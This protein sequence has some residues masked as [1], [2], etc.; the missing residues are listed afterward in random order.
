M[1][2]HI[3]KHLFSLVPTLLGVTILVFLLIH[4]IP[5]GPALVILGEH[6]TE[7]GIIALQEQ[8]GLDKALFLDFAALGQVFRGAKGSR[9]SLI[10]STF[11][12]SAV[13]YRAT[14]G[15][16]STSASRSQTH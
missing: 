9:L 5:G 14:W 4:L 13:C 2:R 16:Q 3:L 15:A 1:T 8:L 10:H 6:A 7:E 12:S 11:A